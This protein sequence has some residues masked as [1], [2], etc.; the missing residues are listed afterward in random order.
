MLGGGR[1]HHHIVVNNCLLQSLTIVYYRVADPESGAPLGRRMTSQ[2][3]KGEGVT[4]ARRAEEARWVQGRIE[5]DSIER[6]RWR[7]ERTEDER[8]LRRRRRL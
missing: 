8:R 2:D 1:W 5:M 3:E 6:R 4:K 7:V